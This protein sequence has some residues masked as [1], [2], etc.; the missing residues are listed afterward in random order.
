[1]TY[2][3]RCD[4]NDESTRPTEPGVYAIWCV[5]PEEICDGVSIA[6]EAEFMVLGIVTP[7]ECGVSITLDHGVSLEY[8]IGW[9]GP[10]LIPPFD[11]G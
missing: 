3:T 6:E 2:W 1:M 4:W 5:I 9:F 7:A 8:I 11:A 10:L